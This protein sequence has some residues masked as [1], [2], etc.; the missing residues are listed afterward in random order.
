MMRRKFATTVHIFQAYL[1]LLFFR[2]HANYQMDGDAVVGVPLYLF[3]SVH[4]AVHNSRL[5]IS[6][7]TIK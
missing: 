7:P 5:N 1:L 2:Q 4:I 3:I 6:F